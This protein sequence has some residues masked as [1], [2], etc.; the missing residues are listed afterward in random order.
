[1]ASSINEADFWDMLDPTDTEVI[2]TSV[3][4]AVET[5]A[6]VSPHTLHTL[7]TY[8]NIAEF[9]T[10]SYYSLNLMA[11]RKSVLRYISVLS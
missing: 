10:R 3:T 4:T 7:H 5:M 8:I 1:M 11:F 6:E 2:S 9:N